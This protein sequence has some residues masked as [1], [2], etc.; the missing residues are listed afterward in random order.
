MTVG[1]IVFSTHI[2]AVCRQ[3]GPVGL[4]DGGRAPGRL[5]TKTTNDSLLGW[6]KASGAAEVAP[7]EMPM[8]SISPILSA[9]SM[10][11][12][13]RLGRLA[14]RWAAGL[15]RGSRTGDG[16]MTRRSGHR[17]RTLRSPSIAALEDAVDD[18]QRLAGTRSAYSTA[19][20]SVGTTRRSTS[21]SRERAAFELAAVPDRNETMAIAAVPAS[22]AKTIVSI[23]HLLSD[24]QR[25][26]M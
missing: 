20:Q 6:R 23:A 13:R 1:N 14:S 3:L 7:A 8:T 19:P 24:L 18:Q 26:A 25:S 4:D 10:R 11:R 15:S 16:A 2:G 17:S 12:V 21:A 22:A 5:P 9:S